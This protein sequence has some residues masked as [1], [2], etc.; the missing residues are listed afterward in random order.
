MK[1]ALKTIPRSYLRRVEQKF[2]DFAKYNFSRTSDPI[3]TESDVLNI[4]QELLRESDVISDAY[5]FSRAILLSAYQFDSEIYLF[6][7]EAE[8]HTVPGELKVL[9]VKLPNFRTGRDLGKGIYRQIVEEKTI[10]P[11]REKKRVFVP[12]KGKPALTTEIAY[13]ANILAIFGAL[14]VRSKRA[15]SPYETLFIEKYARRLGS[16]IHH[17]LMLEYNRRLVEHIIEMLTIASHDIRSPLTGISVGLKVVSKELYGPLDPKVKGVVDGLYKKAEG[18]C[19]TLNK[20]LERSRILSGNIPIEKEVLD[21]THDIIDPV[22]NEFSETF[23]S[24]NVSIDLTFGGI[25]SGSIL[26]KADKIW[27]QNVYRNLFSNV[28]KHGGKGCSMAYG[29]EAKGG[30]FRLNVFNTGR[31]LTEEEQKGLFE[32]FSRPRRKG[33]RRVEGHGLG[34]YS[35]KRIV[36]EHGGHMWY[37]AKSD[38]SNFVFTLPKE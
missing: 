9:G 11:P 5:F 2:K 29:F 30:H 20:S 4:L 16:G 7:E 17:G 33:G 35:C 21:L 31:S 15:L 22:V 10:V 37:E 1:D 28:I 14:E 26:I 8:S 13:P 24:K 23:E 27:L 38:G 12:L 3:V 25:P 18:L 6:E 36:E 34:L 19:Y 32:K